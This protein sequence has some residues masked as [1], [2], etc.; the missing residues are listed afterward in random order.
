MV[1]T[2]TTR[3]HR[4]YSPDSHDLGRNVR[5][6]FNSNSWSAHSSTRT[7]APTTKP[8]LTSYEY[9]SNE[10]DAQDVP[11]DEHTDL[12]LDILFGV[13]SNNTL[14]Q[15]SIEKLTA[16]YHGSPSGGQPLEPLFKYVRTKSATGEK[17][18]EIIEAL[19]SAW[20]AKVAERLAN[21]VTSHATLVNFTLELLN[22]GQKVFG[23]AFS[24]EF[25]RNL[26]PDLNE[27]AGIHS[28]TRI[29]SPVVGTHQQPV[30]PSVRSSSR[31]DDPSV[32]LATLSPNGI[33]RSQPIPSLVGGPEEQNQAAQSGNRFDKQSQLLLRENAFRKRDQQ[34][35]L[36]NSF[37]NR[38]QP[39]PS[40][41]SREERKGVPPITNPLEERKPVAPV[42]SGAISPLSLPKAHEASPPQNAPEERD[43]FTSLPNL[44]EEQR[45]A[46]AFLDSIQAGALAHGV[47]GGEHDFVTDASLPRALMR[48][49][50]G[51]FATVPYTERPI[52]MEE[53]SPDNSLSLVNR[54]MVSR[55]PSCL[56]LDI[57][58][59]AVSAP[60][61]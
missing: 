43:S 59:V 24:E 2:A 15:K 29:P 31:M 41:N 21:T 34:E 44:V 25:R 52:K 13:D 9:T 37:E 49:H 5:P 46:D 55:K 56:T 28:N 51:R 11:T 27:W 38:T 58:G 45:Q 6:R 14:Y 8:A 30:Q 48:E 4:P 7:S 23:D 3:G 19:E 10:C 26:L 40:V 53:S 50:L 36:V 18:K 22:C 35:P 54:I 1:G 61:I 16:A 42:L 12:L 39:A 60:A 32:P 20:A 57:C 47:A 33:K 17:T